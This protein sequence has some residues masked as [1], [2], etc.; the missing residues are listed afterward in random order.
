M[1]LEECK[2]NINRKVIYTPFKSC[3]KSDLEYG[4]IKGVN[5]KFAFVRYRNDVNSKA[6]RAEDL[7]LD[8]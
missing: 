6:T 1:N 2:K 3:D 7:E 5:T 4:V 8:L